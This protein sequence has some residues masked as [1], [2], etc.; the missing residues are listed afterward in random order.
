MASRMALYQ[1]VSRVLT[2]S[3]RNQACRGAGRSGLVA[4]NV[5]GASQGVDQPPLVRSVDL[6][7]EVTDIDIDHVRL[8]VEGEP[9]HV[10]G[11]HGASLDAPGVAHEVLEQRVLP[12]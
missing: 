9:P 8:G 2:D 3:G 11:Q 10:F 5:A 12:G 7:A 4:E 1:S 6:P